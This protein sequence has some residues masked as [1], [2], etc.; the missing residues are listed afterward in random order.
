MDTLIFKPQDIVTIC[1]K[2]V[3]LDYATRDTF[4]TDTSISRCNGNL[5]GEERELE[6]WDASGG[7]LTNGDC[8]LELDSNANGWNVNEMFQKNE[9]IYGVQSTFDQTLSGY[10]VQIEKKNTKEFK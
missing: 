1:A 5:R 6:P 8:D 3:D 9:S 2:N 4:Q 10:T 7:L